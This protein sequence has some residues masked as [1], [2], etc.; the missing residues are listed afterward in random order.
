MADKIVRLLRGGD[1]DWPAEIID[2][3][4]FDEQEPGMP[5]CL[6]GESVIEHMHAKA[7]AANI[8]AKAFGGVPDWHT[9]IIDGEADTARCCFECDH[10][11]V[12]GIECPECGS[13]AG[14]PMGEGQ[15]EKD[16]EV[17]VNKTPSIQTL[18]EAI[19]EMGEE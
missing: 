13:M 18:S 1:D 8:V 15:A 2:Q 4:K 3:L 10:A 14:E 11:Y 6:N 17:E 5:G 16:G 7:Q 12:G 9:D 19:M